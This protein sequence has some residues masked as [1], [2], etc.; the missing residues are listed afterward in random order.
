[1]ALPCSMRHDTGE[2]PP[3]AA[4]P[5]SAP[6]AIAVVRPAHLTTWVIDRADLVPATRLAAA[7]ADACEQHGRYDLDKRD[8]R[9][10]GGRLGG[11]W[12]AA[13]QASGPALSQR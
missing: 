8:I 3:G 2:A 7:F 4:G 10:R 1:M 12:I 6:H 13:P 9:R 5:T 11:A